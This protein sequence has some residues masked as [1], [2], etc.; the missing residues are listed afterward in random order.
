MIGRLESVNVGL[1]QTVEWFGREV[2]TS[3]WKEPVEGRVRAEGV[4]LVGD[5]QADLR[6]HGGP[7]KA[8][9]VYSVEDYAWWSAQGYDVGP[10]TFGEN[11]TVSG[12]DC[13]AATT[14]DVWRIGSAVFGVMYPRQPCFKLGIRMGSAEFVTTFGEAHRRGIYL[15]ILEAGD[16]GAGDEIVVER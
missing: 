4:N 7:T 15:T 13:T 16:V 5:A 3:I 8:V 12:I 10:A 11:F 6:V 2:L 14:G 9:Y 1:P